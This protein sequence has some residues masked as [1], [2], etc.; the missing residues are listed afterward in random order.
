MRSSIVLQSGA[1]GICQGASLWGSTRVLHIQLAMWQAE[2]Q[3]KWI[4]DH[5]ML[6]ISSVL[7]FSGILPMPPKHTFLLLQHSILQSI[8]LMYHVAQLV[9]SV[10]SFICTACLSRSHLEQRGRGGL[11]LSVRGNVCPTAHNGSCHSPA[12]VSAAGL[13]IG[14][15]YQPSWT[16]PSLRERERERERERAGARC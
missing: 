2:I 15:A 4:S 9:S 8:M 3:G 6:P 10:K 1:P 11:I 7:H 5:Q 16:P 12:S 14:G 13:S